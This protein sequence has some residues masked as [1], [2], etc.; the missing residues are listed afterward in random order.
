M[1]K[2]ATQRRKT[3]QRRRTPRSRPPDQVFRRDVTIK[4]DDIDYESRSI[5]V[6]FSSETDGIS[7]L[8]IPQILLHEKAAVDI[9]GLRSVLFNHNPDVVV[10]RAD[11]V[12][13]DE[14]DRK[15]RAS[16]VFDEDPDA[17]RVFRKV[18]GGSI[19]GMSVGFRVSKWQI[20]NDGEKWK[21]PGGRTFKGP[22]DIATKWR[23][24]EFS[25]TPIPAD[26][27]VGVGRTA[28]LGGKEFRMNEE[29]RKRLIALGLAEDATDD[30]AQEFLLRHLGGDATDPA[31]TPEPDPPAEPPAPEKIR[32]MPVDPAAE[33]RATRRE[34]ERVREVTNI[35]EQ[36]PETRG[37]AAELIFSGASADQARAACLRRLQEIRPP[38]G[39][40]Q[41]V[42]LGDEERTKYRQAAEDSLALRMSWGR[43]DPEITDRRRAAARDVQA[44]SLLEHA[45]EF[46]RREGIQVTGLSRD[47]LIATALGKRAI[48]GTVSDY[49]YLLENLATKSLLRGWAESPATYRPLVR[50][51]SVPDF[52]SVSRVKLGDSGNLELTP[53]GAPMPEAGFAE[54]RETYSVA[55]YSKRYGVTRETLINDDLSALDSIPRKMGIAARRLPS[56]LFYALLV[57]A[58]GVGPTMAEDSKALFA[59]DH[60]SGA[61]YTTG[62][63][64][65]DIA[66]LGG[67]RKLMRLQKGLVATGETAPTLNII[68]DY[69]LVPATLETTALQVVSDIT[70]ALVASSQPAWVKALQVVVEPRLDAATNGTTAW[71]LVA[72]PN[73][74]DGAE[75]AF[76]EGREEPSTVRV[77]GTN[78][79]GIE[80]G[81]YLDVGVKFVDHRGWYRAKGA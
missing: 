22:A 15:G 16:I 60:T 31:P 77:E 65:I 71:Y 69:L 62:A 6:S 10:G 49:P 35:C 9:A 32:Q 7:F 63:F 79:L 1:A 36:F 17:D 3:A 75:M 61:N 8:G 33:E 11:D 56:D 37:L 41:R 39:N 20:L 46:M 45:R 51:V 27:T 43:S 48:A 52:K 30:E 14:A 80:W 29:L 58:S 47:I 38:M 72:N 81:V 5:D 25:V 4:A 64:A 12:R 28:P 42:E 70:P 18:S 57:S 40:T 54:A 74:I 2:T 76:L 68:P 24:V 26:A 55:T 73:L 66:N 21:S 34:R 13:I 59:T 50:I 19:E 44:Y 78:I 23:A 53:E 67:A